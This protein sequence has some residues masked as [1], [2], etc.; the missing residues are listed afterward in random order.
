VSEFLLFK[1]KISDSE[2]FFWAR[3]N[4]EK[5]RAESSCE[6]SALRVIRLG[7]AS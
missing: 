3:R 2:E 1:K 5:N 4:A 7:Y 6:L